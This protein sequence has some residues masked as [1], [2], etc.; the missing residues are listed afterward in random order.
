MSLNLKPL[1]DT[2]DLF[3]PDYQQNIYRVLPTALRCMGRQIP[4]HDLFSVPKVK[5]HLITNN[6]LN[7]ER[8]IVCIVDSLGIQNFQGTKLAAFFEELNGIPLSST[9]PSITSAA[10]PSIN[11][12]LP[13]TIHGILGHVIFFKEYGAL[14]NTLRMSGDTARGRDAITYAGIDVKALLWAKGIPKVLQ[15]LHPD[16]VVAEGLPRE[17]PGTGLGRFYVLKESIVTYNGFIDAFGMARRVLNHFPSSPLFTT[18]YFPLIDTLAHKYGA[19]SSE[20]KAGCNSFH[21]HLRAFIE[22]LPTS[23]AKKTTIVLCSDHGQNPLREERAIIIPQEELEEIRDTLKVPPGHSGRVTH[24]YCRSTSKRHKLRKWLQ[25]RIENRA[26][27]LDP[28][29][30][31]HSGLL[32]TPVTKSII[33][34]IGDLLLIGRDGVSL[35]VER[36]DFGN[37]SWGLLPWTGLLGSH[38]SVTTDELLTPFLAFNAKTL[39]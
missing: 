29:E 4:R 18:L 15:E 32:S 30:L 28:K 22:E 34:R 13:P 20:Y 19:Y 14:V 8:V 37:E 10:I 24:F 36:E 12:G 16:V 39:Q 31:N 9:F 6:A 11:F 3:V 25:N 35:R 21:K 38:G 27:L 17:I 5:K 1:A 23:E 26:V 33:Q 7:A 2:D